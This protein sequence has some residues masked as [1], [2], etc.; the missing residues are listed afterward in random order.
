M[1]RN[2]QPA[3]FPEAHDRA[4]MP[5]LTRRAAVS[6]PAIGKYVEYRGGKAC[7]TAPL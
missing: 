4:A 3:E 1:S 7:R 2:R 5:Q 6:E